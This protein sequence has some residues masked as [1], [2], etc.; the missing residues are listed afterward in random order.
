VSFRTDCGFKGFHC[1][2][3]ISVGHG[4]NGWPAM[5]GGGL[6]VC[7]LQTNN[8]NNNNK[9]N[10]NISPNSENTCQTHFLISNLL[11]YYI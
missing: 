5:L 3:F 2:G 4:G 8:N 10:K 9:I 7:L 1:R 11:K 6:R